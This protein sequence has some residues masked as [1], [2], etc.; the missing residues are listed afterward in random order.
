MKHLLSL[1][2]DWRLQTAAIAVCIQYIRCA[3]LSAKVHVA[4][5]AFLI[6]FVLISFSLICHRS[7]G[8]N[9][10]VKLLMRASAV[11]VTMSGDFFFFALL[12]CFT[13]L[14]PFFYSGCFHPLLKAAQYKPQSDQLSYCCRYMRIVNN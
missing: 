9:F 11:K 2:V 12:F 1:Q 13:F 6:P 5:I 3:L 10:P 7:A 4:H 8:H 14:K